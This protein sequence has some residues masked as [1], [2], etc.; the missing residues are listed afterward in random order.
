MSNLERALQVDHARYD[1]LYTKSRRILWN[2]K[3]WRQ[4]PE[5]AY[6]VSSEVINCL[7]ISKTD[8]N[9]SY[10][11]IGCGPYSPLG[12]STVMY[13][14]GME[15]C[16]AIDKRVSNNKR[17]AEALYDLLAAC[18][19]EPK[20][21][22]MTS[23]NQD[24]YFNRLYSFNINALKNGDLNKGISKTPIIY[25]I[26]DL[27]SIP[28]ANETIA[29]ASSRA[30]LEHIFNFRRGMQEFYR[31][32]KPGGVSFHS[33][34]LTDHRAY[35]D[36]ERFNMWSFLQE[37][38][39]WSDG[40]C[41]RLRAHEILEI[42]RNVGFSINVLRTESHEISSEILSSFSSIYSSMDVDE[43]KTTSLVCVFRK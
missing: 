42:A 26:G 25:V 32:M 21:W 23:Q 22:N 3:V 35:K 10:M 28:I 16:V 40:L 1:K 5:R 14:N 15:S 30:T 20:R 24:D 41:N 31:I 2:D 11:E 9:K 36:P 33:I 37:D 8:L 12:I 4:G 38:K 7:K 27:E 6:D 34:D 13:L 43:L 29:L 18:A 39:D 17:S 19:L